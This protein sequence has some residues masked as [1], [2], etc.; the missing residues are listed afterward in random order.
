MIPSNAPISA[1]PLADTDVPM[2]L[3]YHSPHPVGTHVLVPVSDTYRAANMSFG[4]SS[5][6][7]ASMRSQ[8]DPMDDDPLLPFA[9]LPGPQ[10]SDLAANVAPTY[11]RYSFRGFS[12]SRVPEPNAAQP[13]PR[14]VDDYNRPFLQWPPSRPYNPSSQP[15]PAQGT[16]ERL[17][18]SDSSLGLYGPTAPQPQPPAL[19]HR[20]SPPSSI[21]LPYVLP[22]SSQPSLPAPQQYPALDYRQPPAAP[23]Q[24][25]AYALVPVAPPQSPEIPIPPGM[26][27][28]PSID[29]IQ[30]SAVHTAPPQQC[31]APL[32]PALS[33]AD[34]LWA[35]LGNERLFSQHTCRQQLKRGSHSS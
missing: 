17:R 29:A 35:F 6:S 22:P 4:T 8:P 13:A 7:N 32:P 27:R 3:T 20:L 18:I 25:Q 2:A 1:A 11:R 9:G 15:P 26:E 12:E 28:Y 10:F 19:V 21:S 16:L 33:T 5:S 31:Q 34:K 23:T 24:P 30:I 14:F